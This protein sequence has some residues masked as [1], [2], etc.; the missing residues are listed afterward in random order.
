MT[1]IEKLNTSQGNFEYRLKM[2]DIKNLHISINPPTG[3]VRVS[4]PLAFDKTKIEATL[5][6]RMSWIRRQILAFETQP[7]QSSRQAVS[8]E[9][10]Y[11][12]GKRYQL[13][14]RNGATRGKILI[15]GSKIILAISSDTTEESRLKFLDRWYRNELISDLKVL[16]PKLEQETGI[17]IGSWS[18]RKMKTRW[19][20]CQMQRRH[21]TINSELI[22][23]DPSC[24]EYIV[25]HE[26]MHLLEPS[27][28]ANFTR[29]LDQF[30]PNWKFLRNKLN[31][32]PLAYANWEY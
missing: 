1:T 4:A 10:Y 8:G 3:E 6:R 16:I 14:V 13:E 26:L 11:L 31:S 32:A 21:I 17:A 9:D 12:R 2:K 23:K 15:K 18:V 19:G 28:N 29:L 22:K 30:L 20:T 27:H 5:L 25:I 7:R 24:L